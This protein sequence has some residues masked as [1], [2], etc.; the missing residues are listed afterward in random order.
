MSAITVVIPVIVDPAGRVLVHEIE[1]CLPQDTIQVGDYGYNTAPSRWHEAPGAVKYFVRVTVPVP[2]L[3]KPVAD[4]VRG[5]D[6]K[7][8]TV[9]EEDA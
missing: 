1:R 4:I 9:P 3:A 6:R 7:P 2:P 8:L 5:I